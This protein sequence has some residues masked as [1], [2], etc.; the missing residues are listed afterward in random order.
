MWLDQNKAKLY[1]YSEWGLITAISVAL[2]IGGIRIFDVLNGEPAIAM[3]NISTAKPAPA[4]QDLSILSAFDPFHRSDASAPSA[5]VPTEP[6]ELDAPETKLDLKVFGM[7]ASSNESG[8]SAT[9]KTPDGKQATYFVDDEIIP[10]VTLRT[11]EIDYVI[12]AR[13][14][15]SER[16]SMA[17]RSKEEKA[18]RANNVSNGNPSVLQYSANSLL[19][20]IN[21][22]P[23]Y[24]LGQVKGWRLSKR[25]R[26][27]KYETYGFREGD[28][29]TMINGTSLNSRQ[30]NRQKIFKDLRR[31]RFATFQILRD[32]VPMSIEVNL[33]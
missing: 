7:R 5:P 14:G 25:N 12:L 8:S 20:K 18:A 19:R 27:A 33:Q 13:N 4:L 1:R 26:S 3:E 24:E 29:V 17:G 6:T 21:F 22:R 31:A 11:V 10:G 28:I 2:A 9:I 16:L 23:Y 32:E 30:V 15:K